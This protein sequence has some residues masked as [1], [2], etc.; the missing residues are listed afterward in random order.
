MVE[1]KINNAWAAAMLGKAQQKEEEF[2]HFLFHVADALMNGVA[3]EIGSYNGG[4]IA[5]FGEMKAAIRISI[6]IEHRFDNPSVQKITGN[7]QDESTL[8]SLKKMLG[9]KKIDL[10]FI[11]GDHTYEGVKADFEKYLHLVKKGGLIAFHDI[12]DTE[13][14][15]AQNCYV[16]KL[17]EEIKQQYEHKEFVSQPLNWGGIGVL[18]V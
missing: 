17:W 3:V 4:T 5:A 8:F 9:R 16:A 12:L 11:D 14:H 2:K 1:A 10:L 18:K 6:D 7:S 13:E 15:R